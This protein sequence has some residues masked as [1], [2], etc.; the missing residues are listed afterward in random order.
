MVTMRIT[1]VLPFA[2]FSGGTRV[3][4][5]Y[6]DRLRRRGHEVLV[7][8]LPRSSVPLR[9]K[10]KSLI[11][12]RGWPT[13]DHELSH[14]DGLAVPHRVI[15]ARRPICDDDVPNG[16]VV[17]ATWWETAEWLA[18]LSARKGAKAYFVQHFEVWDEQHADRVEATWRLAL[19]KITISQ[20]LVDLARQRFSDDQVDRVLNSVD[21]VQFRAPLREKQRSPT[22]G[23]MYSTTRFKGCDISLNAVKWAATSVPGLHLVAFGVERPSPGLPLPA[24]SDFYFRPPQDQIREIYARCDVWL[25]GSRSEGFHLPPLEAMACRCPVISTRVGGPLDIIEEGVNGHLVDIGD[26]Q[27][28]TERMVRVLAL[29]QAQWQAMSDAAYLTAT[30]YTW[31]DATDLFEA[32]LRRAIARAGRGEIAGRGLV[33]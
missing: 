33:V 30:R 8:S 12:G 9:R 28:L 21:T 18:A 26:V 25:C 10:M 29:P 7:V 14:F 31:D 22:V 3:I 5:I 23:M 13:I 6:A 15:E 1:F 19:H 16:D 2:G 17:I 32:A 27:G 20:W 4:S 24:G 11:L